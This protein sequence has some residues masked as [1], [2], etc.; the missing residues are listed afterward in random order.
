MSSTYTVTR[1]QIIT[2]AL[3]KLGVLEIGSTPDPDTVS[4]AAMSLNLLIKQLS[5]DGLK[6]WKVSELIIPLIAG[7]TQYILGGSTSTL[8]YDALNPT[9]AITDK[10]LKTIQGF[11]RNLQ[12]TPAIDTP[13]MLVSKQEYNVLGSKFSTGTA[14][15]IFYDPRKLNGVLYVYLTPDLNAQTNLELHIIVQ[16]PLDDLNTA[17]DIPDFP[18]EWMNCLVWNLA[19][20]LSL[21]YGVPMN[22]R[23]E[24]SQRAM[25]YK[26]LLSDWDVEASS[27]FFQVDFRSTGANS[28]GR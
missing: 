3:R 19:D 6:L 10:P 9:V 16:L 2:L 13:V 20:Q 4:N 15:T 17:L 18:N 25:T 26:T 14:N 27:T 7:Q 23:Q 24:I 22:T 21:E 11:Y 12:S 28:Y 8:M 5:T 1:D